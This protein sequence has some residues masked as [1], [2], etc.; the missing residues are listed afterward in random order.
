MKKTL[1][2]HKN[3]TAQTALPCTTKSVLQLQTGRHLMN[4]IL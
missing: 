4:V 3:A 2:S 1:E